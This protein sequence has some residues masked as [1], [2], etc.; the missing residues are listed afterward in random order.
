MGKRSKGKYQS[1]FALDI[2]T[3]EVVGKIITHRSN[4]IRKEVGFYMGDQSFTSK[5]AK[6]KDLRGQPMSVLLY[7]LSILKN[8][9]SFSISQRKAAKE[10][11]MDPV[12]VSVAIKKLLEK[13]II[14]KDESEVRGCYF[15][16]PEY[17]WSGERAASSKNYKKQTK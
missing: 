6:D 9:N 5:L 4:Y 11:D 13:E 8:G 10:L 2:L 1:T 17:F 14:T 15:L 7:I 12:R 3:G 16:N